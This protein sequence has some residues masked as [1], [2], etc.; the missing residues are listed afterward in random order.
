VTKVT[1]ARNIT[2]LDEKINWSKSA[3]IVDQQIRG[4]YDEPIAYTTYNNINIK[5]YESEP[6]SE[7]I[8]GNPGS[9]L[10]LDKNGIR[11]ICGQST[12]I[13]I[14]KLQFPGKRPVLV[15]NMI[16]GNHPFKIG[17]KFSY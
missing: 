1:F 16:N 2:R 10:T 7:S 17:T 14:T 12:S 11:V 15:K 6:T 3:T 5:I 9:I 8:N 4:L 13:Y